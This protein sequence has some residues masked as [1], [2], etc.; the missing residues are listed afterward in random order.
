M[1]IAQFS[2]TISS[3]VCETSAHLGSLTDDRYTLLSSPLSRTTIIA[4]F[5]TISITFAAKTFIQKFLDVN[6]AQSAFFNRNCTSEFS[7]DFGIETQISPSNFFFSARFPADGLYVAH[8]RLR[9]I[10][11]WLQSHH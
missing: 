7:E 1:C 6:Y 3:T 11:A 10:F 8:M 2:E 5:S 4:S 9:F